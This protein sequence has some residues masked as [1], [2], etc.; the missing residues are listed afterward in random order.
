MVCASGEETPNPTTQ[1]VGSLRP[2]V[3]LSRVGE[4]C[5]FDFNFDF[6]PSLPGSGATAW[7]WVRGLVDGG[8]TLPEPDGAPPFA[9]RRSGILTALCGG[10]MLARGQPKHSDQPRDG[11]LM[12]GDSVIYNRQSKS[13]NYSYLSAT[14]GSTLVA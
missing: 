9:T 12:E 13:V 4:E 1:H 3:P 7:R 5:D 10:P 8:R 6:Y 14:M 11:G 2:V